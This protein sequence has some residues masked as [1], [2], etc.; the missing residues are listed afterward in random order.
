MK[1][2][3]IALFLAL[4]AVVALFAGCAAKDEA[5]TQQPAAQEDTADKTETKEETTESKEPVVLKFWGGVP[6][7][8]GPADVCAKFNEEFKDKGIQVQYE[9]FVNDD[10][11][12]LKLNTALLSGEDV[13]LFMSYS[14]PAYVKRVESGM[15]TD[16]TSFMER[17]GFSMEENFGS[18]AE[19]Y[20]ADGK[21]YCMPT[22][23]YKY[24]FLVNKDMF[25]EAGIEIP[26]EWTLDEFREVCKKL[27]VGEGTDKRYGAF[28]STDSQKYF[29]ALVAGTKLGGDY[30]FKDGG[31]ETAFDDPAYEKSLSTI[32]GMMLDDGTLVPHTDIVTEKLSAINLFT[33]GKVAIIDA[34]WS[35][36]DLR[37]LE[38]YPHDF[39]TAFVPMPTVEEMDRD[40]VYFAG[41]FMDYLSINSKSE[42]QEEAWQFIKWYTTEGML[43]MVPHG[44]IPASSCF[45]K[46]L[47]MESFSD[48]VD[49]YF[50]LESF[51]DQLL[52]T[53]N[54]YQ[55]TSIT[56]KL[57]EVTQIASEEFEFAYVGSK[58]PQE[59]LQSAKTRGDE[60]LK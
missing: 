44:R 58:T 26:T 55:L 19:A 16:L 49:K 30:F 39:V 4:C 46:N 38:T 8:R 33:Q 60:I 11:G 31:T 50:D 21:P 56:N 45:D 10:S 59:A 34:Y 1:K 23:S 22:Y 6:E 47:I 24:C 40:D 41:G 13:D 12:N 29:P 14:V 3:T 54:H 18:M 15:V 36:R 17:D 57:S 25:D 53:E 28:I 42:H 20:Y 2:R 37:D 48:G 52:T 9:R 7:E 51:K 27:T 5:T 32:C 43:P 35:I